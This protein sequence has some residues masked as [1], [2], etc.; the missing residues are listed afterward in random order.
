MAVTTE[1]RTDSQIQTDVLAALNGDAR[2][3][4]HETGVPVKDGVVT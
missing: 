4:P 2:G 1:T 3:L